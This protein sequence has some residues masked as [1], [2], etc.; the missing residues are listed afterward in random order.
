MRKFDKR[1]KDRGTQGTGLICDK[2]FGIV[3]DFELF[4]ISLSDASYRNF[5]ELKAWL[6]NIQLRISLYGNL[7]FMIRG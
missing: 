2:T 7:L 6:L 1:K 4:D 5:N 3:R